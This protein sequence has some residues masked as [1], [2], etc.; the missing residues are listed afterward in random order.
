MGV[1]RPPISTPK[2]RAFQ[3][4][5]K[6]VSITAAGTLLMN[7]LVMTA[8]KN[9]LPETRFSTKLFTAEIF[10]ILPTKIKKKMNVS[11]RP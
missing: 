6:L 4:P 8:A 11:S 9:S 10:F 7:W 2:S 3:F 5:V 1:P